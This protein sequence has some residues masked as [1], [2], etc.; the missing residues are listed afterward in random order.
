MREYLRLFNFPVQ[1]LADYVEK[2]IRDILV[3]LR[4]AASHYFTE[5]IIKPQLF[6]VRPV[7]RHRVKG[8]NKREDLFAV[9][10]LCGHERIWIP[11]PVRP[12]MMMP[13]K[14]FN[15]FPWEVY[16]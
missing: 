1:F 13:D 11:L 16:F 6:A 12:L 15:I 5:C 9:I 14:T 2:R 8:I 10:Q 4:A 3:K 7:R